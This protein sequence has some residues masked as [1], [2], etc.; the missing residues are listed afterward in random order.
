[1]TPFYAYAGY[2]PHWCLLETP[3]LPTHSSAQDHLERLHVK[4]HAE[5][6]NHL[7]QAQQSS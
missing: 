6:S 7:H 2:P 1:M 3:E 4:I 5:L